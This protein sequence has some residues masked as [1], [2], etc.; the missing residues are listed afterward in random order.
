MPMGRFG[1]LIP[2]RARRTAFAERGDRFL[3]PNDPLVQR[4]FHVQEAFRLFT[5]DAN[6]RGMPVHIATT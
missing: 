2:A 6:W 4:L 5:R 3:L 1:F